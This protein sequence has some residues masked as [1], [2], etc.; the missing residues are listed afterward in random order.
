MQTIS[1]VRDKVAANGKLV[2]NAA[3]EKSTPVLASALESAIGVME[4]IDPDSSNRE[5]YFRSGVPEASGEA[6][7]AVSSSEG[8]DAAA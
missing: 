1:E 8:K 3:V 6:A 5:A 4:R 7:A 2:L